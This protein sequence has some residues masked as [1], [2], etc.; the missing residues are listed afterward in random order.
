MVSQ[1]Q[2]VNTDNIP[3]KLGLYKM[4]NKSLIKEESGGV[5][6]RESELQIFKNKP[7]FSPAP[8]SQTREY[9]TQ[10]IPAHSQFPISFA[11]LRYQAIIIIT[12]SFAF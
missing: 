8:L 3:R 11:V 2:L 6:P 7:D 12:T 10:G 1:I 5:Y 4:Q 9:T